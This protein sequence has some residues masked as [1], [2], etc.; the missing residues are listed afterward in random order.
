MEFYNKRHG[1]MLH[2]EMTLTLDELKKYWCDIYAYFRKEGLFK[3]GE[4]GM[5]QERNVLP[6][7]MAPSPEQYLLL[8]V[9]KK[10]LYPISEESIYGCSE[11]DLFTLIE[12]FYKQIERCEWNGDRFG[13]GRWERDEKAP[14]ED[15]SMYINDI[16]RFYSS[17]FYLEPCNGFVMQLPNEALRQQ[18]QTKDESIPEDV[19]QRLSEASRNYYRFDTNS[20]A[21]RKAIASL[22]DIL[23]PLRKKLEEMFKSEY[24]ISGKCF[25]KGIFEI[26]NKYSIR[27]ND[28]K[29]INDYSKEIWYDWMMQYY[30]SVII[31]YYRLQ[32]KYEQKGE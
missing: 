17:G 2:E 9:G 29:Q 28:D 5:A 20:E 8:H 6:L 32:T 22:A 3:L 30:T 31:A 19:Y 16:L 1:L 27:H 24:D 15:Y 7:K 12:I 23:E 4:Q 21:K 13:N 11:S 26:V 25:D 14:R 10:D 18:L